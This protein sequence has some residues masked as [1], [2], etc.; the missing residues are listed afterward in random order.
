MKKEKKRLWARFVTTT[1]SFLLCMVGSLQAQEHK[2]ADINGKIYELDEKGQRIPLGYATLYFPDYGIGATSDDHGN[3]IFKHVPMGKAKIQVQYV[4]KLSIDTLVNV[5]RDMTID[6]TLRNEDFKLKEVVVTATNSRA[7]RSTASNISRQAMDHMQATSLNDLLALMPGGISQNQALNS[8][9]QINIRQVASNSSNEEALNALG[10]AIIRDGAPISNNSNLSALNPTVAGSASAMGG[11]ASPTGGVDA[12]SISTENIESV[13]IIRGIPSVEYGDLTSGAVIV[14]TKAG[15]EPLRVKAK[16]NPNVYQVSMGTGYE[17]GKDKGALNVSAD[18]AY[19]TN[20]P[21]ATYQ[22]YQRAT[23]KL[24][25]SNT[26]FDNHLRSNTSLDFFYGKDT[27]DRNPD[28]ESTQTTSEGRD[29]GFRLN[30]NGTWSINKGWLQNIRYILS[31][32][33]TDKQSFYETAYGSASAPYSMTTTDGAILSNFAG[34]HIYDAEGNRL[35]NFGNED[36]RHY[37]QL[38]PSSYIGHYE[39]DSREVNAFAKLTATLFKQSGN[40]N[41][42]IL[43]GADFKTD[44]NVGNG[45]TFDQTAPPLRSN[46]NKNSTYRPRPYKDIPFIHQF[47]LFAEENFQW[48]IGERELRIQAGVRLDHASKVGNTWSPRFNASFDLIPHTLTL[49]G[50]YGITAKMPT[51]LYLYPEK[52]YFEYV[53]INELANE[54][55]PKDERLFMTTTKVYNTDNRHLKVAK[56]HKTELGLRLN[57][58]KVTASVTAFQEQLKNGYS[59]DYTFDS[60]NTFLYNEYTRNDNGDLILA[61]SLPVLNS[62]YTPTNH[63]N[64]KTQGVEF[65]INVGRIDAIRTS[66]QLNGALMRT[67]SW[68]NNYEFYDNSGVA[69]S[70]RK[71]VAIYEAGAV[72]SYRQQFATTL[73]ATHNLPQIGFVVTLTA[74]AIWNQANWKTFGN[75]TIPVG[76]ISLENEVTMFPE[77]KYT[78]TE[79]VKADGY[80]YLLQNPNHS[81]A[82]KESYNPYFCFNINVTKEISDMLR[83]SFFA[84]NMFRSYPRMESKRN[85][86]TYTSLNNRFFFG[87]ELSLT[88]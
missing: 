69:A 29:V 85:P 26:F 81:N 16:A 48:S 35:T 43:L 23:G 73:R 84:N 5:N 65:D 40:I 17:L 39:I 46:T 74:Q 53:N 1:L 7:G 20:D 51:L 66:F 9:Q 57:V 54:S 32:S 70:S 21:K 79:Q 58:G 86:G 41:N 49:S 15:R 36:E 83:V 56:N 30:T 24:M 87:L 37:A 59:L 50:G 60:F 42:R 8:S 12:R 33:Y 45:K 19:N 80:D 31:G 63:L 47:G 28:D 14:N 22:H 72:K 88:L 77:G 2:G 18:Y 71:P 82:I 34:Q 6:F 27:R 75:D 4:G 55:I 64:V 76:Y 25:Y 61:S 13:E 62:Y 10:T 52:A 3:F 11:G 44:G 68:N 38:L 78:T 67:Q